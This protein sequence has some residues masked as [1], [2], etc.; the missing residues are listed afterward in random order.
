MM[1]VA[2][3]RTIPFFL[4]FF[5]F[6]FSTPLVRFYTILLLSRSLSSATPA[7]RYTTTQALLLYDGG[8]ILSP[9]R[10]AYYTVYYY[11]SR[12]LVRQRTYTRLLSRL[13]L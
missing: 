2:T 3:E 10:D 13:L 7:I 9:K 6:K 5:S 12:P 4:F 1:G 8:R 11:T